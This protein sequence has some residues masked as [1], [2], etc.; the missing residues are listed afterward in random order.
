MT[1]VAPLDQ[2]ANR[3]FGDPLQ[4]VELL[5]LMDPSLRPRNIDLAEAPSPS[6]MWGFRL[7]LPRDIAEDVVGD[8]Y[9]HYFEV[10]LPRFGQRRAALWLWYQLIITAGSIASHSMIRAMHASIKMLTRTS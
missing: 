2:P 7:I 5:R 6:A 9:E 1:K 3:P 8:L 10:M 4:D